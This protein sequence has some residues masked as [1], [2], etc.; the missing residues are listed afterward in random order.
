M[1]G[2]V[3]ILRV[4]DAC[5]RWC[6]TGQGFQVFHV[7]ADESFGAFDLGRDVVVSGVGNQYT[8]SETCTPC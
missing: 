2:A 5:Y 8:Q 3:R 1:R 4:G 7:G 6:V